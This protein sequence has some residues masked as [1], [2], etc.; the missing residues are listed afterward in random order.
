[1][2]LQEIKDRCTDASVNIEV[3]LNDRAKK[4]QESVLLKKFKLTST[5]STSNMHLFNEKG[6]IKKYESPQQSINL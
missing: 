3:K 6:E 4:P 5:I 2:L 1:M